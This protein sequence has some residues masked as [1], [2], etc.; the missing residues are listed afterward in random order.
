MIQHHLFTADQVNSFFNSLGMDEVDVAQFLTSFREVWAG[1]VVQIRA[2][3]HCSRNRNDDLA[4]GVVGFEE[5]M[6]V[7]DLGEGEDGVDDGLDGAAG[8]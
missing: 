8:Q 4:E 5:A 7:L 3:A 6:S 1:I 2:G